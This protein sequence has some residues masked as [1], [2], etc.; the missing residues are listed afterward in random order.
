MKA[1]GASVLDGNVT[2]DSGLDLAQEMA[3]D[4]RREVT[5]GVEMEDVSRYQ[6][7]LHRHFTEGVPDWTG[8]VIG[9]PRFYA[10]KTVD[11]ICAGQTITVF[12]KSNKKLWQATLTFSVANRFSGD[13][14]LETKDTLYF[15]DLGMLT[16]FDL[17]TG[18]VRWRYNSVGISKLLSDARGGLYVDTT[19]AGPES[20]QYSQ[21][22]N[23][24]DKIHPVLVKLDPATGRE[25]WNLR[26]VG[27]NCYVSGKFLYSTLV[28]PPRWPRCILEE[29][30]DRHYYLNLLNPANWLA[31]IFG[32][33]VFIAATSTSSK[34][35]F[36]RIGFWCSSG[37]KWSC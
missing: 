20:I 10:L 29:G 35:N 37:R 1:K 17:L 15:A 2:A 25:L 28:V 16:R 8:E 13:P 3:N 5:G 4:S 24:K 6:V 26:S 9:P 12:D 18:N 11:I 33:T 23:I 19:S 34:P 7:T 21:Q 22:I 31:W 36:K 32:R 14:C 27:D 30:P